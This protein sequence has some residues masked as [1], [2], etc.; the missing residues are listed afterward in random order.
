VTGGTSEW[1]NSL[2]KKIVNEEVVGNSNYKS[3]SF[4]S[5]PIFG[6]SVS[7]SVY[8]S[9]YKYRV[10]ILLKLNFVSQKA[11]ELLNGADLN[12]FLVQLSR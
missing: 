11:G 7:L 3:V 12:V 10:T 1:E 6:H 9:D 8:Q 4:M 2:H 5:P